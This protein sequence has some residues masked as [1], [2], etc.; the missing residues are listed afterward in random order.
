[1]PNRLSRC[2]LSLTLTQQMQPIRALLRHNARNFTAL[3]IVTGL[4]LTGWLSL[5]VSEKE[6]IAAAARFRF[7]RSPLP[8]LAGPPVRNQRRIHPSLERISSF[9]STLG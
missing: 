1:M 8:V 4:L 3:L 9:L 5:R 6:V 7:S 2:S